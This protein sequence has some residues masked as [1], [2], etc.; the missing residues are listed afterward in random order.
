MIKDKDT[1]LKL[2]QL[3]GIVIQNLTIKV[4]TL[5]AQLFPMKALTPPKEYTGGIVV[6]EILK[7]ALDRAFESREIRHIHFLIKII[8]FIIT[9]ICY[10][11]ILEGF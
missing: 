6:K 2:D 9:S 1:Y 10:S 11:H 5:V 3:Y 8:L 4:Q 7:V